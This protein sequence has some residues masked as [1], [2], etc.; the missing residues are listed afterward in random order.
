MEHVL[1]LSCTPASGTV[2][3]NTQG[4][5]SGGWALGWEGPAPNVCFVSKG[6]RALGLGIYTAEQ[7]NNVGRGVGQTLA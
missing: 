6:Q 3:S 5:S 1:P 2:D 4:K 7:A